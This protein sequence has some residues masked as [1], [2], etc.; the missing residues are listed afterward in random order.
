MSVPSGPSGGFVVAT[1]LLATA[2]SLT[3]AQS[4]SAPV[5]FDPAP[6]TLKIPRDTTIHIT[7]ERALQSDQIAPGDTFPIR[8]AAPLVIDGR[9]I[10]P[11]GLTGQGEVIDAKKSGGGGAAGGIV[12]NAR[13]LMCGAVRVPLGKMHLGAGG[14][15][16]VALSMAVAAGIGP[17]ALFIKG[18]NAAIPL[19][20]EAEAKVIADISLVGSCGVP[21]PADVSH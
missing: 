19:G 13:F 7:I 21:A 5:P 14:K 17:L 11:A 1:L 2:P 3:S 6:S 4:T 15:D 18:R 10:L 20:A 16:H 12:T 9:E 8:L